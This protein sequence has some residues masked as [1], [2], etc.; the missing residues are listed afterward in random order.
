MEKVYS[1]QCEE[2]CILYAARFHGSSR[3]SLQLA[4]GTV[5]NEVHTWNL[6]NVNE[7]G[8]AAVLKKFRRHEVNR[9]IHFI[10]TDIV[11]RA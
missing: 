3:D 1:V 10:F 11:D 5:F 6:F 8:D 7:H 9:Y 4:V 2:R